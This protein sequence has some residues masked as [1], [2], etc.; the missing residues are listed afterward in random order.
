MEPILFKGPQTLKKLTNAVTV[1]LGN[2][3]LFLKGTTLLLE[4]QK[5]MIVS[6]A[7]NGRASIGVIAR[8]KALANIRGTVMNR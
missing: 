2:L 4:Y 3:R 1:P 8:I 5:N 7:Y 6:S